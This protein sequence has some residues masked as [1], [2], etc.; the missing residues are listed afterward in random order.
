MTR[1]VVESI[2]GHLYNIIDAFLKGERGL[3][4]TRYN[5]LLCGAT[6]SNRLSEQIRLVLIEQFRYIPLQIARD[7]ILLFL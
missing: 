7:R 6:Q 1:I 3:I 4:L 2:Q 5:D